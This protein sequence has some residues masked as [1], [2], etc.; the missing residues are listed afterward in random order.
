VSPERARSADADA[1]YGLLHEAA[2]WLSARGEIFVARGAITRPGTEA[3]L[4]ATL[5]L[6]DDDPEI[7]EPSLGDVLFVHRLCVA[8]A[9]AGRGLGL[10]LLDWAGAQARSRGR[11]WLR[12]DC[13]ASNARLRR[14]YADAGFAPRGE[15][16]VG[17]RRARFERMA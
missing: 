3:E 10:S 6:V 15:V 5:Q 7:W 2:V 13:V 1:V 17:I 9:H 8:R 4:A 16:D 14:Y 12:L 11:R